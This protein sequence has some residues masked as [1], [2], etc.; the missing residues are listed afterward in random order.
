MIHW[1]LAVLF[2]CVLGSTLP[3]VFPGFPVDSVFAHESNRNPQKSAI[4]RYAK[5][6]TVLIMAV[7]E[8]GRSVSMG[9]GF[10]VS[11]DGLLVT[12]AHVVEDSSRLFVYVHDQLVQADPQLLAIDPDLDLAALRVKGGTFP[13][14]LL[15]DGMPMEGTDAVAVGY[16]RI[17]DVLQMGFTLHSTI[18]TG[19]ISGIAQGRSR[20][21]GRA[22]RFIQTTGI[23]N[24][25]NS[26]GPLLNLETGEAA[27][28][29]GTTV[30]Y[31]ERARDRSGAAVGSVSLKS[32]IGYSIPAPVI[33]DWLTQ[34]QLTFTTAAPTFEMPPRA[35]PDAAR[36]FATGHVLQMIAGVL[37]QDTDLLNLAIYHYE[38]A[39][40]LR[41]DA[42]WIT[43]NLGHA[44]A[45]DGRWPEAL[46]AYQRAAHAGRN[47][48]D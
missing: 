21:S 23:L 5:S 34:H 12:N 6:A 43:K 10:F 7:S 41:P 16:P 19:T 39:A 14:L 13:V 25:G 27:G 11:A 22:A 26:G 9:S 29:V 18:G 42:P 47:D 1:L 38:A 35:E 46:E 40:E 17:T 20:K 3:G 44:Y 8:S 36:S 24:F 45:A 37:Q 15:C 2:G 32:G 30:P 31:A 28:M 33:R 4:L 48:A